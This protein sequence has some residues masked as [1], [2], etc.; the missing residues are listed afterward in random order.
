MMADLLTSNFELCILLQSRPPFSAV[1]IFLS[2][3]VVSVKSSPMVM[4][5]ISST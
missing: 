2:L 4:S 1:I 5:A 3:L